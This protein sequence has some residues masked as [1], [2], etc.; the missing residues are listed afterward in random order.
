VLDAFIVM[1][2]HLHAIIALTEGDRR[3]DPAGRPYNTPAHPHGPVPGS[4]AAILGQFKSIAAKRINVLRGTPGELVWQRNYYE[5]VIRNEIELDHY[6]Q[7][8]LEN[9][10]R[11]DLDEEN[12]NGQAPLDTS[13]DRVPATSMRTASSSNRSVY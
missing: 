5:H 6:R 11:W 10:V 12:P 8:I 9:P 3:G 2:N 1:P 7:Y 13:P 4:V